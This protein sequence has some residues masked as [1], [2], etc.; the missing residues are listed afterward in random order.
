VADV[1]GIGPPGHPDDT[2]L[3]PEE[4]LAAADE[5]V[6]ELWEPAG[7]ITEA[8]MRGFL[9]GIGEALHLV[10][11]DDDCPDLWRFTDDELA[12]ITPGMTRMVNAR[13]KLA[14][15]VQRGDALLV[16]VHLAGYLGRNTADL[17]RARRERE[18]EVPD[19]G[20]DHEAA[21][22]RWVSH[23]ADRGGDRRGADGGGVGVPGPALR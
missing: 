6:G 13:P 15:A 8:F 18:E 14:A 11:R 16:A 12:A 7:P 10:W 22:G 17:A 1:L 2:D 21:S 4:D 23:A 20:L 5:A 3:P 9:A 19:H